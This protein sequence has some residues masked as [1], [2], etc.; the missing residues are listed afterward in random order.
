MDVRVDRHHEFGRIDER[1]DAEVGRGAADHPAEEEVHPLARGAVRGRRQEVVER[2]R[3]AGADQ[4]ADEAG[5]RWTDVAI[6]IVVADAEKLAERAVLADGR[7]DARQERN[8]FRRLV[9]TMGEAGESSLAFRGIE[10][11]QV[12]IRRRRHPI[13]HAADVRDDDVG[14]AV[15]EGGGEQGRPLPGRADR[16]SG[17]RVAAD[18]ARSWR[19][20]TCPRARPAAG[21]AS[22]RERA[23]SACRAKRRNPLQHSSSK[24]R[25]SVHRSGGK[26][27]RAIRRLLCVSFVLS[28]LVAPLHAAVVGAVINIDGKA[29]TG[30]KVSLFAP[31]LIA[32][33]GPRLMSAEPQRKPL[34]TVTTDSGGKFTLDVPKDQTVVDVR[35][36]AAGYA[37]AGI[38]Y[39]SDDDAG[40]MLLTQAPMVRGT[41]TANGKPVANATV[42]IFGG[43]EYTTKTDADGHYS[44]PDPSK[45]AFRAIVLHPD[46]AIT[47]EQLG[48]NGTKKKGPDFSVT[49]GVPIAG[50]VVAKTARRR[51]RTRSSFSMAGRRG[52]RPLTER[53][54]SLT[55]AR[56]GS[57][58]GRASAI[59]SLSA[60]IRL[61]Q[62][63]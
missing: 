57:W 20:R 18:R 61:P 55:R 10:R 37:P 22:P 62:R 49:A 19:R 58:L 60:R 36:D 35:I 46:Y 11:V 27:M 26:V 12:R 41:I 48:P 15:G 32:A 28:S 42:A 14:A 44:A 45:W 59:A 53:S 50:R 63:I 5:Q 25:T 51:S 17:G 38:R 4:R 21:A 39:L 34:A 30:A 33:Q 23:F 40:A 52:S 13:E 56:S 9:E 2:F 7:G 6:R 31:E 1:P 24:V 16:R 29:V 54:Q 8:Q 3:S 47:E 43:A